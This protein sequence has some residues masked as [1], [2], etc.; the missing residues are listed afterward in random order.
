MRYWYRRG[1]L[2]WALWPASVLFRLAV[3]ARRI[4]Y[5]LRLAPSSHPGIP[6]IVV[7]NLVAGDRLARLRRAHRDA[8]RGDHRR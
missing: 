1:P 6:V 2:A 4:L 3:T 7:G 5:K 8:A